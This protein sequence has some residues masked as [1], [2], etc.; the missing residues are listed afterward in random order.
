MSTD[1]FCTAC[2]IERQQ[3]LAGGPIDR[4]LMHGTKKDAGL[5]HEA[6]KKKAQDLADATGLDFGVRTGSDGTYSAIMMPSRDRRTAK[7]L[8]CE[9]VHCRNPLKIQPGHGR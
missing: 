3:R 8:E 6:A 4:C 7:D 1:I 2:E 5:G 9:I